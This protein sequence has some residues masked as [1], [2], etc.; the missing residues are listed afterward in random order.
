MCDF[1]IISAVSKIDN[2]IGKTANY[3]AVNNNTI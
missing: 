1:S 2:G 3:L